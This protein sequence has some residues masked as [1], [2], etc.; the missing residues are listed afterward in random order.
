MLVS[1]VVYAGRVG[2]SISAQ[3]SHGTV[4]EALTSSV[5]HLHSSLLSL[6]DCFYQPFPLSVQYR[7]ITKQAPGGGLQPPLA[8]RTDGYRQ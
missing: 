6:P 7:F 1:R 5:V 4:R 2:K 8:Q 3:A